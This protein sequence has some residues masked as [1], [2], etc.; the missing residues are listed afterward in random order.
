MKIDSHG[1]SHS[2]SP[3]ER[4]TTPGPGQAGGQGPSVSTS[5]DRAQI[6]PDAAFIGAAIRA[7]E[8]A[9]AVRAD[10][11]QRAKQMLAAGELGNDL[12]RLADRLIDHLFEL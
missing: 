9:P 1:L 3:T 5:S 6:S 2:P 4:L 8:D 11:V 10:V 12:G 7:A